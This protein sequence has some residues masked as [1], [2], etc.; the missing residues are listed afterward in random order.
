MPINHHPTVPANLS[1]AAS[2]RAAIVA[3]SYQ[4]R[5]ATSRLDLEA[6]QRLR[7]EVFNLE[8]NEGLDS[9]Y[10]SGLDQDRF[11]DICDHLMVEDR[12]S[13][14]IVGT[15]RL[16]AG[17][18]AE[19]HDGYYS[20]QEFDFTPF[21]SIRCELVELGRA[22]VH[23]EHRKLSVLNLLWRG[24]ARYAMDRGARYLIGCSS[25]TSQDAA[26]GQAMY[27]SLR[28]DHLVEERFRTRPVSA[29]AIPVAVPAENCPPPP[30]LLR[31]YLAV[32][33]KICGPPAMD[34]EFK[35]IDFLTFLDMAALPDAVRNRFF[36]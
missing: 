18:F 16:Q 32:G 33:A 14:A 21:K 35:T 23:H 15:Y 25:L 22:C 3:G 9:A 20:E 28:A 19:A 10:L 29:F 2:T 4:L 7:F 30:K 8:L 12:E 31:A 17:V 36:D 27:E 11:D 1:T 26:F 13:G 24:I 6:A 34:R 5:L